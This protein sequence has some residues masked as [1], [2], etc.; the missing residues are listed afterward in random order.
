MSTNTVRLTRSAT[1]WLSDLADGDWHTV[2]SLAS[3]RS[4]GARGRGAVSKVFS[5]LS[6]LGCAED[7]FNGEA[8]ALNAYRITAVGLRSLQAQEGGTP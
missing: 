5:Q 8:P 4:V 1:M 6:R 7:R 3:G 2:A